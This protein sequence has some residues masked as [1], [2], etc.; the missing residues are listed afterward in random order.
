MPPSWSAIQKAG[1]Y[2]PCVFFAHESAPGPRSQ[3]PLPR[4][5]RRPDCVVEPEGARQ[6][7]SPFPCRVCSLPTSSIAVGYFLQCV[8]SRLAVQPLLPWR[9]CA[10]LGGRAAR[11]QSAGLL[12]LVASLPPL[13]PTSFVVGDAFPPPF[14]WVG[15]SKNCLSLAL[16]IYEPIYLTLYTLLRRWFWS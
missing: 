13:A 12:V 3:A 8:E 5:L 10:V 16:S 2:D 9:R 11:S 14:G 1:S 15:G 6:R 7:A 4:T